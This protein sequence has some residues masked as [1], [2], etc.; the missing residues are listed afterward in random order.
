MRW[1]A[2]GVA[3]VAICAGCLQPAAEPPAS[4]AAA[5][6]EAP[7]WSPGLAWEFEVEGAGVRSLAIIWNGT[8]YDVPVA[9]GLVEGGGTARLLADS[10][11][12]FGARQVDLH[13]PYDA[14][15]MGEYELPYPSTRPEPVLRFP[16]ALDKNWTV[17]WTIPHEVRV[18]AWEEV[19]VPAGTFLAY[20]IEAHALFGTRG[21]PGGADRKHVATLHY[22]PQARMVIRLE[23]LGGP[24]DALP[25]EMD[26]IL[27]V[28]VRNEDWVK[29]E[30]RSLRVEGGPAMDKADLAG[31][32][33]EGCAARRAH[34]LQERAERARADMRRAASS[35]PPRFDPA[36]LRFDVP[37]TRA[38]DARRDAS[39]PYVPEGGRLEWR[40]WPDGCLCGTPLAS[41][42]ERWFNFTFEIPGKYLLEALTYAPTG[43]QLARGVQALEA[44][45]R[46]ATK[47]Q[48]VPA[49]QPPVG[50]E[51]LAC[52]PF[53][54]RTGPG[55]GLFWIGVW[56]S[57]GE[58]AGCAYVELLDGSGQVAFAGRGNGNY[59]AD[60]RDYV[61]TTSDTE[62]SVVWH[63]AFDASEDPTLTLFVEYQET[64]YERRGEPPC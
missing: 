10:P 18:V 52:K 44:Q 32:L 58:G 51:G 2:A 55:R 56:G 19:T 34:L 9:I 38:W 3:F 27:P 28:D 62:W 59:G 31:R 23:H 42:T 40:L 37:A 41:S 11:V 20:R 63:P 21:V 64:Y 13:G 16:L 7:H 14:V 54:F 57:P 45:F 6:V 60:V 61:T 12:R 30:L 26:R 29:T 33:I 39:S 24:V 25:T 49:V 46:V 1:P 8:A 50:V 35:N 4:T 17:R 22:S 47:L 15:C 43:E 5:P 53:K 48:C 36:T